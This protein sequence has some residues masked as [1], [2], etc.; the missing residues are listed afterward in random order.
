MQKTWSD[1]FRW[2]QSLAQAVAATSTATI[3][4]VDTQRCQL[5]I[6]KIQVCGKAFYGNILLTFSLL[7]SLTFLNFIFLG[8]KRKKTLKTSCITSTRKWEIFLLSWHNIKTVFYN[9]FPALCLG[10]CTVM[11]KLDKTL[12]SCL[13][14][15]T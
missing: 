14:V 6:W 11:Q 10:L 2:I 8:K 9:F 13:T 3:S 15:V 7:K 4:K 12:L 5:H 1:S